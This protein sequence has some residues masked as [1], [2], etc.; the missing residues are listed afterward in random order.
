M[1]G[2][3]QGILDFGELRFGGRAAADFEDV[4][5]VL[6]RDHRDPLLGAHDAEQL[7]PS[8]VD[9]F[10]FQHILGRGDDPVGQ[11]GK[12]QVGL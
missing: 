1:R 7:L 3:A 12:V 11:H 8:D 9:A 6:F 5:V 10:L 4:P 2:Y